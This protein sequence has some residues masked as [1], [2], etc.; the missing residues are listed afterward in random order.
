M[1]NKKHLMHTSR[2]FFYPP[3]I[4]Q[5]VGIPLLQLLFYFSLQK[6]ATFCLTTQP[7]LTIFPFLDEDTK[8]QR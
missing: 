1:N 8:Q 5:A 6:N 3:V 4:T 7:S 2:A